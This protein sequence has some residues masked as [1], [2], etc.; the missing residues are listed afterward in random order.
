MRMRGEGSGSALLAAA[1]AVFAVCLWEAAP[2][3]G[4]TVVDQTG[5][6]VTVPD[7][8]CRVVALAP[9][10]T[11]MVFAL[12]KGALLAGATAF[13]D[14]PEEALGLPAVGPYVHPDIERIAA[15]SPDL[16]LAI[17]DGNP[18]DS[19]KRL[20]R[21]GIP[22]YALDPRGLDGVIQALE[23]LG[24]LLGAGEEAAGLTAAIRTCRDRIVEAAAA[25]GTRPRVFF[26]VGVSPIVSAGSGTFIHEL[27]TLAGGEN[28][29]AGPVPWPRLNAEQ[30]LALNPE[31]VII[32]SMS[33]GPNQ[34]EALQAL[35]RWRAL[36]AAE[37][38]R[39]HVAEAAL[40][41]RPGPRLILAL[42]ILARCVHPELELEPCSLPTVAQSSK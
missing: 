2:A 26:Q 3:A 8:P 15:L 35:E 24:G 29:T 6:Q 22:V 31:V 40:F 38:G 11:E 25:S 14:F 5:R 16:C 7:R 27:I 41:D 36:S 42:E 19:V 28:V 20:E 1:A 18:L 10:I 34:G 32:T 4:R 13:S 21:L 9:S 23:N 33:G 37:A 12:G 30:V 39:I 17:R